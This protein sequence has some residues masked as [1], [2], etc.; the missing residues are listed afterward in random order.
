MRSYAAIQ[1]STRQELIKQIFNLVECCP[2]FLTLT[3]IELVENRLLHM[4]FFIKYSCIHF[5]PSCAI[6]I[7]V[8]AH[9]QLDAS[10]DMSIQTF[11][12]VVQPFS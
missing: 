2:R 8:T 9:M 1:R 6:A 11:R 3:H 12:D 5:S 10:D 7:A 4:F